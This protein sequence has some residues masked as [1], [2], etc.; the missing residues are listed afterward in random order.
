MNVFLFSM[1]MVLV[2]DRVKV[3]RR[4]KQKFRIVRM[5]IRV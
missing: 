5:V 1:L 3:F 2:V 4:K